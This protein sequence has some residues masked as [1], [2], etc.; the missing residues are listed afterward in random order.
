MIPFLPK[1]NI[2]KLKKSQYCFAVTGIIFSFVCYYLALTQIFIFINTYRLVFKEY[3]HNKQVLKEIKAV[4]S[5]GE[6]FDVVGAVGSG[7][8]FDEVL[9]RIKDIEV[10]YENHPKE[11]RP[12]NVNNNKNIEYK[13]TLLFVKEDPKYA[14]SDSSLKEAIIYF[15]IALLFPGV[16]YWIYLNINIKYKGKSNK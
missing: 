14:V 1:N 2:L 11:I 16:I 4:L 5:N 10:Y 6:R 7:Y 13:N 8:T 3:S 15:I 12:I 9:T